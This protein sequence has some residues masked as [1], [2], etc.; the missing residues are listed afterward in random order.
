MGLRPAQLASKYITWLAANGI[1]AV[2]HRADGSPDG[3]TR[4][5][6]IDFEDR[7][8]EPESFSGGRRQ[9]HR[10]LVR[11]AADESAGVLAAAIKSTDWITIAGEDWGLDG[12]GRPDNAGMIEVNVTRSELLQRRA[13]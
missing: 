13:S 9:V 5:I 8:S 10:G 6:K 1:D 11:L 4:E 2:Y 7:G 12:D 3:I